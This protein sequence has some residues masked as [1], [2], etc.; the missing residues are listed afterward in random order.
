[1]INFFFP[2]ICIICNSLSER[3]IDLCKSCEDDL[4]FLKNCC[5]RCAVPLPEQQTLCGTCLYQSP[6]FDRTFALFHY[7]EPIDQL[8][9]DLKFNYKLIN[10]RV[11]GELLAKF[12]SEQYRDQD[13]PE[14]IIPV[15]LHKVRLSERGYNQVLEITRVVAKKLNIKIDK[16]NILRSKNT[17]AQAL[18][19]ANQRHENIKG[20]FT[21]RKMISY[22]HVVVIDD[23]ITTGNTITELCKLLKRNGVSK[24]DVWCCARASFGKT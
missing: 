15:P 2:P 10:A 3:K 13:L 22:K 8:I 11:L 24:I 19:P 5:K 14:M 18:L 1:M 23:V 20:A 7:R 4:P 16:S 21:I 17:L 12:L 6:P 9:L